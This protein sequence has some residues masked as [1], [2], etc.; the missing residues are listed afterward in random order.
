[1]EVFRMLNFIEKIFGSYSDREVKRIDPI[2]EE[3]NSFEAKI[4]ELT[5]EQLKGKT[6]EFKKRLQEGETLEEI[7]PEA[8]AVVREASSR[9]LG[10][11]H[12]DVQLIGGVVLHQ[13]RISEMKTGEG[14]TLV[15]TLPVYLNALEGKG[16]HIV[17]VND[18]LAKRDSEWM[19]KIYNFLGLTV[20]LIV[21]GLDNE[22]RRAAYNCDITY[23]TNNEYGFDYL[24]D[25]MVTYKEEMVQRELHYAIVDEVDSILIDEARTPLIISGAGDKSTDLYKKVN[26]FVSRLKP[27]VFTQMDDKLNNDELEEDYVVD[28][29]AHTATL[30]FNGVKKTEQYFGIEN[31]SD[32]ENITLQHHINQAVRA[33]GLMKKDKDYVVKDGEVI[34]VDEFTG[35][36]MYGRR[37][38]DGLHQAIEAKEGVKVERESKT[39]AT[40]TFQNYFRMYTKLAGMTGTALTEEQEFRTIYKLDVVVIPTNKPM[41]R[42]DYPDSVYKNELG[43]FNAVISQVA[44]CNKNGQP[45]LIGTISIEK[46]ELLSQMLKR[47]GISH[48][49]LNA[50]HHD[51][52]AEII[53]QAGKFGAVTIA[54]NMAGRGTDIVL[55]GNTEFLAKQEMRKMGYDEELIGL[56]TSY[57]ETDDEQILQ[58]RKDFREMN[59]KFKMET[60]KERDKVVEQ[61]GLF[62]IGTERHESRR[63]D[64]QLRG[65][66]GRQGDPGASRFYIS[67]EDDLMRLFGSD[68]VSG[69]V[70]ALG[71]E[72]DQPIEHRMLSNAIENSQK[73][74]EG[75]NFDIRKHVLQY[76][77]VMN[78]QREVIYSQRKDVLNGENLK[79]YFLKMLEVNIDGIVKLYCNE[80]PHPDV[81]DWDGIRNSAG[82]IF[83]PEGALEVDREEYDTLVQEDLKEKL[84]DI[85]KGIY[86]S[87]EQE[88]GSELMRE[89][90]RVILLRVVDEKWMDHIDAMDQLKHGIG[91]RAYGQRDP[92]VEYRIEGFDMFEEMIRNIQEDALRIIVHTHLDKENNQ[93]SLRRERV[94]E[95]IEASHGDEP[96]NTI[97]KSDKV[98]RNDSCPC[99]SGKKYKKCCGA[100]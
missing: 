79:N 4:K 2:I 13:G 38:S 65:R 31:L 14:K 36:L 18:Y 72:D 63:I 1:M 23:G 28:E 12:F 61:G 22:E 96:N 15:A 69:L 94:A 11:R 68:K 59:D 91:L 98:G 27:K 37:Y 84:Y 77:D 49:V 21:H 29:K 81:W 80:S 50:K 89:L 54:T 46:S 35:R 10:M 52:E 7:L 93:Q 25:N 45:V 90:E 88:F 56:S 86:E 5:D 51:K 95:P 44:E 87:K 76:D 26:S 9:V 83:L 53:A 58:A 48:Q 39:L 71:L 17:T 75:K 100:N 34:I 82:N 40:I 70:N 67:L 24:R 73:R 55:G 41:T 16:V 64:N 92:V 43:K 6:I 30:S 97:A 57:N 85:G 99:G 78:K 33:H 19:G 62:I 8:F 3:V 74:V 60:E 47:R 32:T 66:S 42:K 20:G